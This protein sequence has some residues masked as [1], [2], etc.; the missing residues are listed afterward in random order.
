MDL[1]I[2]DNFLN[3]KQKTFLDNLFYQ[4]EIPFF[5]CTHSIYIDDGNYHFIHKLLEEGHASSIFNDV[6]PILDSFCKKNNISYKQIFRAAFNITFNHGND[7]CG[8]HQDHKFDHNQLII[9]LND[10]DGDTVVLDNKKQPL[11]I[12]SPKKFRGFC[13]SQKF[14]YHYYPR[15][16]IRKILIF[17]FK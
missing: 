3:S 13:F 2:Q 5:L 12:V 9:Y 4:R 8:I 16:G 15:K 14:H 6:R 1:I 11:K 17:T 10:Q 7:N